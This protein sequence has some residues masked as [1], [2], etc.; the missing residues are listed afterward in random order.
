M[1]TPVIFAVFNRPGPTRRVLERIRG[2]RPEKL[3]VIAD[4]PRPHV[5]ADAQRSEETRKLVLDGVDWDCDLQ[6]DFATLLGE[7]EITNAWDRAVLA[8]MLAEVAAAD[9]RVTDDEREF[10]E[11]FA[12][13]DTEPID[14]L[15]ANPPLT[16]GELEET[17]PAVREAMMAMAYAVALSDES[18][19]AHEEVRL[20]QLHEGLRLP[21]DRSQEL[22]DY[23]R[24]H[25]V[26]MMLEV[27]YA[28]GIADDA[29]RH[30]VGELASRLGVGPAEVSRLDA[31]LRKRK[32]LI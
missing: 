21:H 27:V 12:G 3:Y 20:E 31:R 25:I 24:E 30:Q 10:F 2:A 6:T 18:F 1:K 9:G 17:T 13:F 5:P 29:E 23:A 19:D 11:A 4:G 16:V 7:V 26:D 14:R 22:M 28:D 8:R 32:G 15:V